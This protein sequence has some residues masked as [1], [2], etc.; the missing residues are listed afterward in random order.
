[1][2]LYLLDVTMP[3]RGLGRALSHQPFLLPTTWL[4]VGLGINI[5]N[6]LESWQDP[7]REAFLARCDN[8]QLVAS[9]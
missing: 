4:T 2:R 6:T 9:R 7:A 8:A 5:F 1:M 3:G